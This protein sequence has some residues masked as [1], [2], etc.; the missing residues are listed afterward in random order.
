[1]LSSARA[2]ADGR[3][4]EPGAEGVVPLIVP[5]SSSMCAVGLELDAGART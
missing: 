4:G 2:H 3:S 5:L 1:M